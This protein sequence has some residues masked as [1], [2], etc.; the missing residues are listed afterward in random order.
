M[1]TTQVLVLT[2]IEYW[3]GR[4]R[5]ES[6]LYLETKRNPLQEKKNKQKIYIV[7][8]LFSTEPP[9]IDC[10]AAVAFLQHSSSSRIVET[11]KPTKES[12]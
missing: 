12:K 3:L 9:T 2:H 7:V 11:K 10:G 4:K 5:R 8:K 1:E 6:N